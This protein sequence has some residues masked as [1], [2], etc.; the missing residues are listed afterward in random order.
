MDDIIINNNEI[1][2]INQK[3]IK[4]N[5]AQK[6]FASILLGFVYFIV[7]S[8]LMFKITNKIITSLGG[9]ELMDGNSNFAGL[10][11][12]TFIFILIVRL[13]IF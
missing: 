6:W 4:A 12:H 8:A 10:V 2:R 3:Y 13:I 7:S 11:L 1:T 9:M 5:N